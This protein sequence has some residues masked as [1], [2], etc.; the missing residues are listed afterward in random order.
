MEQVICIN[1]ESSCTACGACLAVCPRQAISMCED[2]YGFLYPRI[3]PNL[4]VDCGK[5]TL[6]CKG[7]TE[8][9]AAEPLEAYAA[10]GKATEIVFHSASGG[11]F[12]CIAQKVLSSGGKVA[13]AIMNVGKGQLEVRHLLSDAIEDLRRMQGSK[14]VQ[15][16]AWKC[17]GDV[18]KAVKQG[19]TVLFSGTPCQVAAVKS[20]TG[21]PENLLT[22]DIVCHGVPSSAMLREYLG[23]LTKQFMG[24]IDGF[25][26]RD[27]SCNKNYC[28]RFDVRHAN[29]QH[30]YYLRSSYISFYKYFLE[31][32]INRKSCYSCPYACGKRISDVTIGDYWGVEQIH[33]K[34]INS[35]EFKCHRHWSCLLVNTEKGRQLIAKYGDAL[36]LIPSELEWIARANQQLNAPGKEPEKRAYVLKAFEHGGYAEVERSFQQESGGV[37]RFF[38]RSYKDMRRNNAKERTKLIL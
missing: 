3:D 34:E 20:I 4:C 38:W 23:I 36:D 27:K 8:V 33:A 12:A 24:N 14:Y 29:R 11:L 25:L 1:G 18:I 15:S 9:L 2:K 6:A 19:D 13:G 37:L 21:D 26:F 31:S 35:D 16:D 30:T 5:C 7:C 28:A 10:A 22:M 17:Y 32:V